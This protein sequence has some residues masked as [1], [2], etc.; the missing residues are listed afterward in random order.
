MEIKDWLVVGGL[1]VLYLNRE[2]LKEA[3]NPTSDKNVANRTANAI[4]QALTG[5]PN[6]TVGTKL[7]EVKQAVF[8]ADQKHLGK[9]SRYDKA[10]G[11]WYVQVDGQWIV[12]EYMMK[13]AKK[14]ATPVKPKPAATIRRQ[15]AGPHWEKLVNGRWQDFSAADYD[16]YRAVVG[17]TGRVKT[18]AT[19]LTP[20]AVPGLNTQSWLKW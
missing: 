19:L 15:G 9:P 5:D 3:L 17:P 7:H 20:P 4:T 6:A 11:V 10:T 16:T 2:K 1:V 14:T 13:Q 8:N 12:D 18:A